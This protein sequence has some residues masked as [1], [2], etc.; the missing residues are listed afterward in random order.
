MRVLCEGREARGED[1]DEE[2][3]DDEH[4]AGEQGERQQ[5]HERGDGEHDGDCV[6]G[7]VKLLLTMN[8]K[9]QLENKHH[10]R[11]VAVLEAQGVAGFASR[12][13][14]AGGRGCWLW[15]GRIVML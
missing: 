5:R 15:S 10:A 8:V 7:C 11:V 13:P 6:C 9:K 4:G 1:V 2:V 3:D 12:G 14:V